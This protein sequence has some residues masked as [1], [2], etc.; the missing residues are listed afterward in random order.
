MS[1]F[2]AFFNRTRGHAALALSAVALLAGCASHD[3]SLDNLPPESSTILLEGIRLSGETAS[4]ANPAALAL[5]ASEGFALG[6]SDKGYIV[7][8]GDAAL[9]AKL[10]RASGNPSLI[11]TPGKFAV[12]KN[13][14][15]ADVIASLGNVDLRAEG[16][17]LSSGPSHRPT[18]PG[19]TTELA[20]FGG[21]TTFNISLHGQG[22][23]WSSLGG[24]SEVKHP[25]SASALVPEQ[26]TSL[27]R[28]VLDALPR[29][30]DA[31]AK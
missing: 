19:Q 30:A 14:R 29:K 10:I 1:P 18:G 8:V 27:A 6:L 21:T 28:R 13:G 4:V 11:A 5:A 3:A 12:L 15:V 23:S 31:T 2:H 24:R 7:V 9:S 26:V 17:V 16:S 20:A 25:A 22:G